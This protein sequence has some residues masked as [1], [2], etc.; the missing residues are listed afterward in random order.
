MLPD[1]LSIGPVTIHT[2]GLLVALGFAAAFLLTVRL[3]R[4]YGLGFQ[5]VVDMGLIG[6]SAGVAGSRLLFILLHYSHFLARPVEMLKI[7]DGGL[8][9]SG[10][11]IAVAGAMF[12]YSRKHGISFLRLGDLWAPG[13]ALGQALGRLGCFMAGC[14]YG[15]IMDAPWSIIF[16]HPDSL[17]P[18]NIPLHPTQLYSAL[19]GFL[20]TIILL[21]LHKRRSFEGRILLWFLIL[22]STG[23]LLVERFRGDDRN[24]VAGSEM[25]VSQLIALILLIVSVGG[26]MA[27]TSKRKSADP[28]PSER[29]D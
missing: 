8:I 27:L 3:S 22:H 12:L 19:S 29:Q 13:V 7:W 15:K 6:M 5:Q 14:C 16:T 24:L 11:L 20:I 18:L 23:L 25:S 9:F 2:N 10:G 1:L 21:V 26:L 28:L 4:F 17:A